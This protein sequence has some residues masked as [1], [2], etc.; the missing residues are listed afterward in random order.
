MS[1]IS[2]QNIR[3]EEGG[4][5]CEQPRARATFS[6]N[7]NQKPKPVVIYLHLF[8]RAIVFATSSDWFIQH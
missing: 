2:D 6:I 3:R 4:V 5:D 1:R 8:S 7:H